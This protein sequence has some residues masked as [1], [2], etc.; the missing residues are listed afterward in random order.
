MLDIRQKNPC[1]VARQFVPFR[2]HLVLDDHLV[3]REGVGAQG[4]LPLNHL[5][6]GEPHAPQGTANTLED[7]RDHL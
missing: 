6:G 2:L 3:E 7:V 4:A 1:H 5:E